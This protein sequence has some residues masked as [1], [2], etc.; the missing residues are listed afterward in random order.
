MYMNLFP[1][2]DSE[3]IFLVCGV[4]MYTLFLNTQLLLK[5]NKQSFLHQHTTPLFTGFYNP[6]NN[7]TPLLFNYRFHI[8][9]LL[10][11]HIYDRITPYYPMQHG[12]HLPQKNQKANHNTILL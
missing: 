2:P 1:T 10:T 5:Q 6:K 4:Q 8:E 11:Y 7:I 12:I 3:L 9:P